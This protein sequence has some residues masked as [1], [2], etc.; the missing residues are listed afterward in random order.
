MGEKARYARRSRSCDLLRMT[1]ALADA[2]EA[3]ADDRVQAPLLAEVTSGCETR[4]ELVGRR[5][6]MMRMMKMPKR[7]LVGAVLTP[8]W[9]VWAVRPEDDEPT[10]L[11][12]RLAAVEITDYARSPA[13]G[14]VPDAGVYVAGLLGP[15]MQPGTIFIGLADD[16]D[17]RA[18]KERLLA[19]WRATQS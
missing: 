16:P 13:A 3:W 9:L 4:S 11:G 5:G 7:T 14:L 18:F 15:S 2:I 12:V 10:V 6:L 17:G 8:A 19:A 1:P